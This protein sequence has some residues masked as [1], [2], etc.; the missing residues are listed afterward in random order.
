MYFKFINVNTNL[1]YFEIGPMS[2]TTMI[3]KNGILS[4]KLINIAVTTCSPKYLLHYNIEKN[5]F[6]EFFNL[7]ILILNIFL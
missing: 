4:D 3:V 5:F 2:L 7:M 6:R 1:K